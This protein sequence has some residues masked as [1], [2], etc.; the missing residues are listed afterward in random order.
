MNW[1]KYIYNKAQA[2][3][4]LHIDDEAEFDKVTADMIYISDEDDENEDT[5]CFEG[6]DLNE[7]VAI[8]YTYWIFQRPDTRIFI[9]REVA[10]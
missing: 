9:Y 10:K 6:V 7:C 4:S 5:D 8:Y 3:K 1:S 2:L